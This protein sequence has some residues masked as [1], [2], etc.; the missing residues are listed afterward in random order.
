MELCEICFF[1]YRYL[2]MMVSYIFLIVLVLFLV[3]CV[4]Y[5]DE[6]LGYFFV[7]FYNLDCF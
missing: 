1:F 2:M 7:R 4:V 5:L 6:F 3:V